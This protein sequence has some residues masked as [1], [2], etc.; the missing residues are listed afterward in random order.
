[1]KK[2][3]VYCLGILAFI[4]TTLMIAI[5]FARY[6]FEQITNSDISSFQKIEETASWNKYA[7]VSVSILASVAG[8]IGVCM[9]VAGIWYKKHLIASSKPSSSQSNDTIHKE[10]KP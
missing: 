6:R 3:I 9:I 5:I 4:C 10:M 1:M 8:I 7:F 2:L